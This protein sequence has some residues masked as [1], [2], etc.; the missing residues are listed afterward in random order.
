[1][2]MSETSVATEIKLPNKL[3]G[4]NL[5]KM[6]PFSKSKAVKDVSHD[7]QIRCLSYLPLCKTKSP[8][9]KSLY[10]KQ[11]DKALV[12][13]HIEKYLLHCPSLTTLTVQ[14]ELVNVEGFSNI[15]RCFLFSP[16][17]SALTFRGKKSALQDDIETNAKS[18]ARRCLALCKELNVLKLTYLKVVNLPPLPNLEEIDL[19]HNNISDEALSGLVEGL[20][21]CQYLKKVKLDYNSLS[22]WGDF[23]PFLPNLEEINLSYNNIRDEALSGLAKGLFSSESL[24]TVNLTHNEIS[25]K[26]ALL[27]LLQGRHKQLQLTIGMNEISGDLVSLLCNLRDTSEVT[28]LDLMKN[29]YLCTSDV[30]LLLQFLP[31]LPNLQELA[32]CVSCQGEEEAEHINQLY[33]V[34]HLLKKLKL[35]DC[36]LENM[37]KLSTQMFQHLT[38]L[39]AIDLSN[40]AISDEAVPGLVEGLGSCQNLKKVNFNYNRLHNRGDFLPPLPNLEEIDLIGNVISDEA[41]PGLAG[42]LVSCQKLKKVHLSENKMSDVGELINTFINLPILT[43]VDIAFNSIRDESLPAIHVAAWLKVSTAVET[44]RL[45]N[46]GFSAEGVRDFVRTMKGKAYWRHFGVLLYDGSLADVGESV[47]SGGEGALREE[48]QWERLRGDTGLIYVKARQL[49]VWIDHKG[50]RSNNT[51][52]ASP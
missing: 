22:T 21:S 3:A 49:T 25:N 28:K 50:P 52:L 39:E 20:G 36:S 29:R 7:Q 8:Y 13:N 46:N 19:S 1:M 32:L 34:R 11:T 44:V 30:H 16:S 41:V 47:E 24:T 14:K 27:L 10:F 42:G 45:D 18:F 2:Y 12:V 51:Q 31:Q 48:Q 37:I 6:Y 5:L 33:G 17:L 43:R 15:A 9:A 35:K 38:L 26:G 4:K 23:L 40:N